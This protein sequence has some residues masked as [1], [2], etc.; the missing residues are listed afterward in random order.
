MKKK[1]RAEQIIRIRGQ[2]EKSRLK[3]SDACRPHPITD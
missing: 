2:M 1:H 3:I